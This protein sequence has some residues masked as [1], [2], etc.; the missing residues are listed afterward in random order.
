MNCRHNDVVRSA[1]GLVS[2]ALCGCS[3]A[4]PYAD[5]HPAIESF[6]PFEIPL[7]VNE[8]GVATL[9]VETSAGPLQLILDTGADQAM[10]IRA[11]SPAAGQLEQAGTAWKSYGSGKMVRAA[12]YAIDEATLGPLH[13]TGVRAVSEVS[14]FPAFLPGD[15]VLG[16]GLLGEMTLDIDL[17]RRRLGLLP[18]AALPSDFNDAQWIKA[19]LLDYRNGPVAAVHLDGSS[20][21]LRLVLDTGAIAIGPEGS[22][23]VVELPADLSPAPDRVEGLPVYRARSV[24]IGGSDIGPMNFFV[25]NH[26]QPPGTH[27]FLGNALYRQHRVLIVPASRMVCIQRAG[28]SR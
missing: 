26:P 22:Y 18:P 4:P 19:P 10:L 12:V 3:H 11:D 21:T 28:D 20:R 27:G 9:T 25:V 2:I 15:G 23:G 17:P 5:V 7:Q 16:R 14:D 6:E 1:L 8:Q 24:R 13:Y